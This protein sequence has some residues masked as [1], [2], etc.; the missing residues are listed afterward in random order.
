MPLFL[1]LLTLGYIKK[2]L[3]IYYWNI[4]LELVRLIGNTSYCT[5]ISIQSCSKWYKIMK[6]DINLGKLI[7][8]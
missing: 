1:I 6:N 2:M 5:V 7:V 4:I 3:A 8:K